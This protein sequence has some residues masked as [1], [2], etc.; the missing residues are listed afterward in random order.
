MEKKNKR[1]CASVPHVVPYKN[2]TGCVGA[3]ILQIL[4]L[5]ARCHLRH[6]DIVFKF[7]DVR[8]ELK[9]HRGRACQVSP[10]PANLSTDRRGVRGHLPCSELKMCQFFL[11]V[12]CLG[13]RSDG[14]ACRAGH[15]SKQRGFSLSP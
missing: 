8:C 11:E 9:Q 12:T 5:F 2:I 15:L 1:S 3:H 4:K 13:L 14:L 10:S 7:C 6:G